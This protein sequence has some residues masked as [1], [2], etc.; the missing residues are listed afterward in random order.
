MS[1]ARL[2]QIES[3]LTGSN[4]KVFDAVPFETAWTTGEIYAELRRQGA[5]MD[6][7]YLQG[8]LN[9]LS[10]MGLIKENPPRCYCR[11][12]KP[13]KVV[14]VDR[15]QTAAAVA[16]PT[17]SITLVSPSPPPAS[18][19]AAD[20]SVPVL[21]KFATLAGDLRV[22]AAKFE[23]L[24]LEVEQQLQNSGAAGQQLKQL[25]TLLRAIGGI[26]P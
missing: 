15:P 20:E 1:P 16:V 10:E 7:R 4:R 26:S 6:I 13:G 22:I 12:N 21:N 19:P 9:A 18:A 11:V 2:T 5:T 23:D 3:E 25:Q 14:T 8:G 17:P 24:A